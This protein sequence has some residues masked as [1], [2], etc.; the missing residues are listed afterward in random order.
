MPGRLATEPLPMP[1]PNAAITALRTQHALARDEV[2]YVGEAV[3]VVIADNRY[4]AEDAAAAV[5][6]DYEVLPA[7]SDCRD[8]L[9]PGAPTLPQRSR[10][11][12]RRLR[13]DGLWRCR[14]RL[15][16]APPT[17]SRRTSSSTAA[18]R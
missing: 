10:R 11:Q 9:A 16:D 1:V 12:C 6:V 17:C 2:C 7:V 4:L 15:R 3:A 8:A 14:A 5:A 13:S 18:P